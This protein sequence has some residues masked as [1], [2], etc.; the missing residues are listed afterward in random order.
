MPSLAF[1]AQWFRVE[2]D[3]G[4]GLVRVLDSIHV[5]D[6]GTVLDAARCRGQIEGAV[7]QGVGT[8]LREELPTDTEGGITTT[9]LRSYTIPH[10]G[11]VPPT[12]VH[13]L[14]PHDADGPAM[15]KPMSELPFNAVAAAL[16]NAVRDATGIRF[17]TLPLRPDTVW[18]ALEGGH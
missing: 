9:D 2:V 4:T 3:P 15:P 14:E 17:T 1:S 5:A 7:V 8:T 10:F 6:A 16:A 11:E 18:A 12:E 13:L